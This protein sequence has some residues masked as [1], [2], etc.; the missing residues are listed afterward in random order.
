MTPT[1]TPSPRPKAIATDLDGTLLR[2]DGTL[3]AYTIKVLQNLDAVGVKVIFVTARP[4]RWLETVRHAIGSHGSVI[5]LGG[6]CRYDAAT[7]SIVSARGFVASTL[8]EIV[9]DLRQAIPGIA[10]GIERAT[11]PVFDHHYHS[12][13]PIPFD[14][15]RDLVENRLEEPVGKLLARLVDEKPILSESEFFATVDRIV[16]DRGS[17]AYSGAAGLAEL[18]A[19]D[20]SKSIALA[21]WCQENNITPAEVWAFGDMPNDL[22]M[23]TWAG[24]SFAVGNAHKTVIAACTQL[25]GSNNSDGVARTL[26]TLLK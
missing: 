21:E 2:D 14:A 16:A 5:C 11:G 23:L 10:L 8:A 19:P 17:L 13:W 15:P 18:T 12:T 6:A 3:S 25:V 1:P 26:H 24:R 4:P 22:P 9:R 20:I 7:Q